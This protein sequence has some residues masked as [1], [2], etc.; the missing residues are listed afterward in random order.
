MTSRWLAA[1]GVG[2]GAR[3]HVHRHL[4]LEGSSTR[5]LI[6]LSQA[7]LACSLPRLE[8]LV[9][10]VLHQRF[11]DEPADVLDPKLLRLLPY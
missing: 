11:K 10:D 8:R 4:W 2:P 9:E 7:C 5:F 1:E 6:S 3:P